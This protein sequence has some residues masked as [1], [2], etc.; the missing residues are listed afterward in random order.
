MESTVREIHTI[1]CPSMPVVYD[2]GKADTRL[3]KAGLLLAEIPPSRISM[4]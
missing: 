2:D 3:G 1:G 4:A